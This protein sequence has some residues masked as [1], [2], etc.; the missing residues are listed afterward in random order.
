MEKRKSLDEEIKDFQMLDKAKISVD[1]KLDEL[2]DLL[3]TSNLDSEAVNK[4]KVKFNLAVNRVEFSSES[5]N[6]FQ[7]LDNLKASRFEMAEN[8]EV[9]LSQYQLDSK[10]SKKILFMDRL[11]KG[12]LLIIAL[13][14]IT[15]GFGMIIMPAPPYFE[16]FTIFWFTID[17]GVTLMDL[18]ALLIVFSGV[19]LFITSL[20]KINKLEHVG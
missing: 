3:E 18:I 20:I 12:S 7:Q 5:L 15:L 10:V 19:Y 8:L 9:L 13:I 6:D 16:M 11:V 4:I 17:D 14:L 1:E 2:L